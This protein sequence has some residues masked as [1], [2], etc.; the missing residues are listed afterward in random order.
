MVYIIIAQYRTGGQNLI[1][2]IKQSDS[3]RFITIHE[4]FNKKNNDY[5][6]DTTLQDFKWLQP[7][8]RYFLK[9]LWY[10]DMNYN[11]ILEISDKIICLYRENINEQAISHIYSTKTNKYHHQYTPKDVDVIL[12]K[13][14]YEQI[15]V[16]LEYNRKTLIDFATLNKIE[17]ISYEELYYKNGIERF[18]K[19]FN[20]NNDHPFPFGSKY[21]RNTLNLI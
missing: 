1:N 8:Q 12:N 14:E 21:F 3:D 19:Y 11:K 4:P 10:P 9:E 18:K 2:W 13:I 15:K 7:N 16:D 17:I 20:L 6:T 5:T